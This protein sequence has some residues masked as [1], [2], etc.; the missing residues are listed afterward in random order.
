MASVSLRITIFFI[1]EARRLWLERQRGHVALALIATMGIA[2]L[3]GTETD[4]FLF[5][6]VIGAVAAYAYA[7]KSKWGAV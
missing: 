2:N 1:K 5:W 6:I 7:N 4:G 3:S